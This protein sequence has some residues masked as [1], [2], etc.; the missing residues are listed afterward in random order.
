MKQSDVHRE[1]RD[2]RA[3]FCVI[4]FN[5]THIK[6]IVQR[7]QR[8]WATTL[9][10]K[11]EN[12]NER[13]FPLH[14]D[15]GGGGGKKGVADNHLNLSSSSRLTSQEHY[16]TCLHSPY[17]MCHRRADRG[18]IISYLVARPDMFRHRR[19]FISTPRQMCTCDLGLVPVFVHIWSRA[20]SRPRRTHLQRL[21]SRQHIVVM[22]S[23]RVGHD[24]S[25]VLS[26]SL[27]RVLSSL[28]ILLVMLVGNRRA[29]HGDKLF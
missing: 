15:D 20:L 11:R 1:Q 16:P 10:E 7:A 24:A 21:A 3:V 29:W 18:Q 13:A 17:A 6:I 28:A 26:L 5:F 9:T 8:R 4:F 23:L 25:L 12:T 27:S 22:R 19:D 2:R 14:D